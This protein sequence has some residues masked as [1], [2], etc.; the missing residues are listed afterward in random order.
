MNRPFVL[1]LEEIADLWRIT[2]G[3]YQREWQTLIADAF[4]TEVAVPEFKK[5]AREL[6]IVE[7]IL[8]ILEENRHFPSVDMADAET[9]EQYF[10]L[11]TPLLDHSI[12][13]A[14]RL[15]TEETTLMSLLSG[16]THD[17]GKLFKFENAV[18]SRNSGIW[19]IQNLKALRIESFATIFEA[20]AN[21]HAEKRS[22][23]AEKVFRAD[24]QVRAEE[25]IARPKM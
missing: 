16:L 24:E 8:D 6:K 14:R 15:L 12:A 20:V 11:K 4:W 17:I 5:N 2:P 21:H 9:A 25:L 23:P 18:H 7:Y 3:L 22:K 10:V 13:V 19:L 1:K